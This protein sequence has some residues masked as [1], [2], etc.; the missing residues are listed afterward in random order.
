MTEKKTQPH[1]GNGQMVGAW[2]ENQEHKEWSEFS[3][4]MLAHSTCPPDYNDGL[5]RRQ[6]GLLRYQFAS[7]GYDAPSAPEMPAKR[8]KKPKAQTMAEHFG[9]TPNP[10]AIDAYKKD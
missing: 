6:V 5:L 9:L 7:A 10:N 2:M 8:S 4:A 3:S 1:W